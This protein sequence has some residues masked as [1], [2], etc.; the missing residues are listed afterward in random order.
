MFLSLVVI[1]LMTLKASVQLLQQM[2]TFYWHSD[3]I[4]F[5]LINGNLQQPLKPRL[6]KRYK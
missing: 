4:F 3:L 6:T 1:N 5:Q 2:Y